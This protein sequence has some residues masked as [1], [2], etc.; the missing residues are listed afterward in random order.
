MLRELIREEVQ[1]AVRTEIKKLNEVKQPTPKP[2]Q[3]LQI[4]KRTTPLVTLDEPFTNI[5]GTLG[6]LLNETAQSMAGFGEE[7]VEQANPDFPTIGSSAT[8]MFVKDYSSI[9]KKSEEL[10]NS[11]F[12]P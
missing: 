10:S 9:L 4:N 7:P 3:A 1:M 5:G 8:D 11:N 2:N 12:R 6:S